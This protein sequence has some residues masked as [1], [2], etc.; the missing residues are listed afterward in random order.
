[1]GTILLD[2]NR[3][4]FGKWKGGLANYSATELGASALH[5]LIQKKYRSTPSRW[6]HSS[7]SNPSRS[8]AES[9]KAGCLSSWHRYFDSSYY[10]K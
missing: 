5:A 3:T 9:R 4:P 1:M 10:L 7:T 8:G 2:G 6:R